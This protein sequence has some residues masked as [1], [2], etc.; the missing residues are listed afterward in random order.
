MMASQRLN[1]E[2]IL[3]WLQVFG[4]SGQIVEDSLDHVLNELRTIGPDKLFSFLMSKINDPNTDINVRCQSSRALL[5]LDKNKGIELLLPFFNDT[6]PVFR[7]DICGLMHEFGDGRVV[8]ALIDRMKNDTDPQIR[9]TAAYALGGVGNPEIIPVL[10]ETFNNDHE[11]DQLGYSPSFCA[12][13]A[14]SEIQ[15]KSKRE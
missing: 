1:Q 5:N 14:I 6:D 13:G 4:G 2:Q 12:E 8:D 15:R 3:K 10:L 11:F 9:G 7:W